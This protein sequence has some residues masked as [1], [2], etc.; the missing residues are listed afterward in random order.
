MT[1]KTEFRVGYSYYFLV[2]SAYVKPFDKKSKG[3]KCLGC[4]QEEC[5]ALSIPCLHKILGI[6]CLTE[7]KVTT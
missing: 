3:K 4:G 6:K 2:S 1:D 7:G 5:N